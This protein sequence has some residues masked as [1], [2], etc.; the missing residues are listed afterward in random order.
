[1]T[2]KKFKLM[3]RKKES[4]AVA[5]KPKVRF[6]AKPKE[7]TREFP[8]SDNDFSTLADLIQS[9]TGI[10]M[11]DHKKNMVYGRLVRRLRALN[12]R[13]FSDYLHFLA[14]NRGEDEIGHLVNAI[15]TNLTRF[16]REEHHFEHL[17][18][19]GLP[20]AIKAVKQEKQDRL[21]L[22]SAGCSSGEEAYSMAMVLD[23]IL[24]VRSASQIDAKILA[25][26][27]DSNMLEKGRLGDYDQGIREQV[28]QTYATYIQ[29]SS[30]NADK[31]HI[32]NRLR[33]Y[34]A[35]KQL[36]LISKW[37]MKGP[38]DAI[39][40]RNVMIYFDHKTKMELTNKLVDLLKP[41]GW[42]YLG[43][44]ENLL[45]VDKRLDLYGRTIYRRII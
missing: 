29:P 7:Q 35:F 42:L 26:D 2:E 28:P 24:N 41:G 3:T 9:R 22:W 39:F 45:D 32:S 18:E 1:M 19:V 36:N 8:F 23:Q 44:S 5:L 6:I 12:I 16:F 4:S 43:H 27:L 10:V 37:P 20:D 38:F 40:C 15:T 21:R 17:A 33:D 31:C 30:L 13:S 25:T 11:K 14:G 34:I